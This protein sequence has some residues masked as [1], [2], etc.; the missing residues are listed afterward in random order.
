MNHRILTAIW[1]AYPEIHRDNA[2]VANGYMVAA[3]LIGELF[4]VHGDDHT[5][6]RACLVAR[7]NELTASYSVTAPAPVAGALDAYRR[8][9]ALL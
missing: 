5:A 2:S 4:D 3:E 6:M 7:V 8:A 9:L 1:R